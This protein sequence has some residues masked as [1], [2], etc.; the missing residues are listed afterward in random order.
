[1]KVSKT[2]RAA[3]IAWLA[4]I[5]AATRG[6][7]AGAWLAAWTIALAPLALCVLAAILPKRAGL[8]SAAEA[9]ALAWERHDTPPSTPKGKA[10]PAEAAR[11][12]WRPQPLSA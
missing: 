10:I 12:A 2:A 4:L 5:S 11:P 6:E 1:M 9:E 8:I 3:S 7:P